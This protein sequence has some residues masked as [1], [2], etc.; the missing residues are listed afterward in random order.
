M[1]ANQ[2]DWTLPFIDVARCT[3]CGVCVERCPTRAVEVHD[4][5]AVIVRPWACTF[6]EV[7]ETYCP[8]GAI[9]RPFVIVF[10]PDQAPCSGPADL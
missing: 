3:G 9:G 10:A 2:T 4:G 8:T 7:C 6:C 1:N 5:S